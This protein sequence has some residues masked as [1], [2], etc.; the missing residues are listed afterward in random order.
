LLETLAPGLRDDQKFV[1]TPRTLPKKPTGIFGDCFI[2]KTEMEYPSKIHLKIPSRVVKGIVKL[3]F[4]GQ[5][6]KIV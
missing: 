6:E 4:L 3:A 1:P 5:I 2:R